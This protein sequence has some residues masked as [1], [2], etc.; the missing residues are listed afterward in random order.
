MN[1]DVSVILLKFDILELFDNTCSV[2]SQ[3]SKSFGKYVK[4]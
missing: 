1:F 4:H 2:K 3:D